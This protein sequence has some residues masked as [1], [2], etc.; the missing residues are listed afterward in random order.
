MRNNTPICNILLLGQTGVGKS[1]L[2]NYLFDEN[3]ADTDIG[4]PITQS[5]SD[6]VCAYKKTIGDQ[7][8][9]IT[10]SVGLQIKEKTV[11]L[12]N[13]DMLLKQNDLTTPIQKRYHVILYCFN[14]GLSRIQDIDCDIITQCI[15]N[16][17]SVVVV[18]T[19]ADYVY[20]EDI[21]NLTNTLKN[22]LRERNVPE[23]SMPIICSCNSSPKSRFPQFGKE[24]ILSAIQQAMTVTRL[25][26]ANLKDYKI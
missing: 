21:G 7:E 17:L 11:W 5:K 20:E 2:L 24:E 13:F 8:V 16:S 22:C 12:K 3:I 18:F 15:E 1:S 26:K 6:F 4:R 19:K 9:T 25:R 23:N 10:E 14:C